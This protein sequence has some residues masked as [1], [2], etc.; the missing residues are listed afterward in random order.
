MRLSSR[1]FTLLLIVAAPVASTADVLPSSHADL[2]VVVIIS[3][4]AATPPS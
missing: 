1:S 2:L 4:V 3:R